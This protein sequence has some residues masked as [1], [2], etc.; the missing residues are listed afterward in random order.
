[1]MQMLALGYVVLRDKRPNPIYPRWF[2]YFNVWIAFMFIP[3]DIIFF[4]KTG[5]FAW[6]G[7]FGFG[8]SFA[9]YF[10]WTTVVT[11]MTGK[12]VSAQE[13]AGGSDSDDTTLAEQVAALSMQVA[14]L[15]SQVGAADELTAV[16]SAA[17]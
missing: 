4:F 3:A 16:N 6:N 10:G 17:E 2:G 15:R 7:I 1:M 9:A 14:A 8:L 11:V 12:A 13:T 5:P